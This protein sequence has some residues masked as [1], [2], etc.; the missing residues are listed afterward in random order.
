MNVFS[1]L[2]AIPNKLLN[3]DGSIT[4]FQGNILTP[5]DPKMAE[6]YTRSR[7]MANKFLNNDNNIKTYAEISVEIFQVVNE[8]PE[9]GEKNKIYLVPSKEG[10]FDEYFYNINNKWDKIGEVTVDLS[11]YPTKTEVANAIAANSTSDKAYTDEQIQEKI[12]NVLG[13]TY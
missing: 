12:T 1:T 4:D 8:L 2:K 6:V 3:A 11:N 13:G 9:T 5:A 10:M 7:A